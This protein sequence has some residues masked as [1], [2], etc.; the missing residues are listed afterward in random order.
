MDLSKLSRLEREGYFE[1]QEA[2]RRGDG[3][4]KDTQRFQKYFEYIKKFGKTNPEVDV[5]DVGCGPGPLEVY[6]KKFGYKNV[7]ALDFSDE[8]I[9]Q[10]K[11]NVPEFSYT[12]GDINEVET[13]YLNKKF[14]IVFC[15]QVLEHMEKHKSVLK[16]LYNLTANEGLLII[17][18][19]WDHCKSN[20]LHINHYLPETFNELAKELNMPAP[21]VTER[22]GEGNL[23][24]LAI[25]K[26]EKI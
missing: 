8:G 25:F 20:R 21:I 24:L 16:Q 15:L 6:L 22:F 1:I 14:D 3:Y 11:Q 19:P 4:S 23:Q 12:I 18:V 5:L 9:R 17:S 2:F 13:I 10:C 26:N 7:E